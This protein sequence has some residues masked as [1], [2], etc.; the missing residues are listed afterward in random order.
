[1]PRKSSMHCSCEEQFFLSSQNSNHMW[2]ADNFIDRLYGASGSQP[3]PSRKKRRLPDWSRAMKTT[4]QPRPVP[5]LGDFL[6]KGLTKYRASIFPSSNLRMWLVPTNVQN[7]ASSI[8]HHG[9]EG[10]NLS[11]AL[12]THEQQLLM[13]E[14]KR[15]LDQYIND[16]GPLPPT[17]DERRKKCFL[18]DHCRDA[19]VAGFQLKQNTRSIE[20][21]GLVAKGKKKSR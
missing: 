8:V 11:S 14:I 2:H 7:I 6:I 17:T 12:Y 16:I 18:F 9:I 19:T 3:S 4:V 13:I 21:G 20:K 1:M 5:T 10:V 15:L